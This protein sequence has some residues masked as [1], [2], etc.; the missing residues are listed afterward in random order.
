MPDEPIQA[1]TSDSK[2]IPKPISKK[3]TGRP[4]GVKD[5]PNV[6]SEISI[7]E[8][9]KIIKELIKNKELSARERLEACRLYSDLCGDRRKDGFAACKLVFEVLPNIVM[10][11]DFIERLNKPVITSESIGTKEEELHAPKVVEP[12]P[13]TD[14]MKWDN[15]LNERDKARNKQNEIYEDGDDIFSSL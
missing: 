8:R 4:K 11:K 5:R 15:R 6:R 14:E 1:T 13:L 2:P 3:P 10:D 7:N 12:E 9:L